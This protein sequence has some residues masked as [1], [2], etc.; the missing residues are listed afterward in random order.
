VGR[1]D[2]L[3]LAMAILVTAVAASNGSRRAH[4]YY[5]NQIDAGSTWIWVLGWITD[6]LTFGPL[7]RLLPAPT[8]A[9]SPRSA[10][11]AALQTRDAQRCPLFCSRRSHNIGG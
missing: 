10:R 3:A 11:S 1:F 4:A 7:R 2:K 9:D 8:I 5:L 6:K